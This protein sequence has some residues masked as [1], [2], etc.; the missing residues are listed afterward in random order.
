M[1]PK[2]TYH[3]AFERERQNEY[4]AIDAY[5]RGCGFAIERWRLEGAARVLAC[6]VKVNPPNWQHGRV[7]YA[8]TRSFLRDRPEEDIL[9]LDIGTAK[10]FS[11]LCL[12]WALQDSGCKGKIASVDVLDPEERVR[13]NSVAEVEGLLKLNEILA[14][15][16]EAQQIQFRKS[17]GVEWLQTNKNER[18]HLAFV[19][20]KHN[21][22]HASREG[23]LLRRCQLIGDIIIFDDVQILDVSKAVNQLQDYTKDYLVANSQRAYAIA[24]RQ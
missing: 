12:L 10:G 15:W 13:R 7:I 14:P 8:V 22:D 19:D 3:Q 18:V 17:T 2:E 4:P 9:L 21:F 20:G 5:E 23:N 11:A 6:P 16:P 24:V 1:I